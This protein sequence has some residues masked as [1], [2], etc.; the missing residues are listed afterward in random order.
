MANLIIDE[1]NGEEVPELQC[2]SCETR[3]N[4]TWQRNLI[5]NKIEYC[6][7]CGEEIEQTIPCKSEDE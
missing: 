5:Y 6:P 4:I 7:F 1:N 2:D 3:F